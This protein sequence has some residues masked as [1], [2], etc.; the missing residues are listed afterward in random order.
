MKAARFLAVLWFAVTMSMA[1]ARAQNTPAPS[2]PPPDSNGQSQPDSREQSQQL[3]EEQSNG[4]PEQPNEKQESTSQRPQPDVARV[5]FIHGDASMQRGDSGE[6]VAATLNT[7]LVHGDQISTG[8]KSRTEI[9]LDYANVMRLSASSQVKIADLTR[10]RIQLQ[11]SQGYV[12]YSVLKGSEA[13]VEIDSPN[14]AVHPLRPGRYRVQ[15]N[16]DYETDVIVREGEAE[17]T[18][19]QGSTTVKEGQLVTIR[20]TENPEYKVSNAPGGDD[21]DRWNRD[22]DRTINDAEGVQKTNRYYTGAHDLD[23]YGHWVYVPGYGDVW[24]PYHQQVD[25]APYQSGRWVWEPYY[26]WT[27]VSYE[28]WGWAPYH[29]GRWFYY[30]SAWLWWPGPI[31]RYYRPVWAPAFVF[32]IGFGHRG[33]FGFGSIG[34]LPIGPSD[35]FCPWY[36]RGR[37]RINVVNITNINVIN[38]RGGGFVSPL[39][40]HGHGREFSNFN[41]ALTDHHVR[42][43]IT[44]V[45]T[46]DFGRGGAGSRRVGV[47][48]AQLREAHLMTA[49][50]P[51]VP[52]RE[53]LHPGKNGGPVVMGNTSASGRFFTKSQPPAGPPSFHDQAAQMQQ[54]VHG[55]GGATLQGGA[56]S[57]IN[58]MGG[59]EGGPINA[60]PKGGASNGVQMGGPKPPQPADPGNGSMIRRMGG[61]DGGPTSAGPKAGASTGQ[62][63]KEWHGFPGGNG[64]GGSQNAPPG[65]R[66]GAPRKGRAGGTLTPTPLTGKNDRGRGPGGWTKIFTTPRA[67]VSRRGAA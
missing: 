27:W 3:P 58:R 33:G 11:V 66:A 41:L 19:P 42:G 28:P 12:N 61:P 18:T 60:A 62:G 37:N 54:V 55:H 25:W 46:E 24:Q 2:A 48:A 65:A 13:E 64:Q 59:P 30:D 14:V 43:G 57:G 9:Q 40:G 52:T 15:V 5:S 35:P 56:S 38:V 16:S 32:F 29:Y 6:W 4:L 67:P 10:T 36:G 34:W 26:G 47:D 51:V 20:G 7:P 31:H 22:R 50:V 1:A 49:N 53:S 23:S 45:S 63:S 39:R 44:S 17:I 21:W 8:D